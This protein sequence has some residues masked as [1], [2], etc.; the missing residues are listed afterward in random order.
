MKADQLITRAEQL[1]ALGDAAMKTAYDK[2]GLERVEK[3]AYSEFR[4]A[5]LSFFRNVFGEQHPYYRE[6]DRD[7]SD[8]RPMT[9]EQGRGVVRAAR[10]EIAGGWLTSTRALLAADIFADFLEMAQYLLGEKFKDP[11]AVIVGS[12]LEEHLRQLAPAYG[13]PVMHV[14]KDG[15][16]RPKKTEQLNTELAKSGAYGTLDQKN[17]TAW[18]DLRNKAAHGQYSEYSHE[19]VEMLLQGVSNFL[20]RVHP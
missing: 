18:L 10:D 3:A 2:G 1:L 20:V 12:V 19:Q 15:K 11:A 16:D 6:F 5:C 4:S 14:T 7:V 13:V 9:I 17:V 8:F